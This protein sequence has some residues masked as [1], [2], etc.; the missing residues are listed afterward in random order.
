MKKIL[1]KIK[2]LLLG[3]S[4]TIHLWVGLILSFSSCKKEE[5]FPGFKETASGLFYKLQGIGDG[6]K[7]PVIGDYLKLNIVYKTSKDS[8]FILTDNNISEILPL[9]KPTFRGSFEEGLALLNEADSATYLVNADSMFSKFFKAELPSF[10]EKGS[11]MK[12]E[13]K[14]NKIL[15]QQQYNQELTLQEELIE[16]RD[17]EEQ[18]TLLK[19]LNKNN[20]TN[21]PIENGLYYIPVKEGK[22][23]NVEQGKTLVINYKG[24]FLDGKLFDSTY[25]TE[26]MEFTLMDG[27]S[28]LIKGLEK[29]IC[30]MKEG[31]K[32]K[33]II[34]SLL[35][36]SEKGSSTS[37]VP[38][39]TTVIYEVELIK[40]VK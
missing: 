40:V 7:K 26:P 30:L 13:V 24:F 5:K 32:A 12:I 36:F 1:Q 18:K 39:Y 31:G 9:R 23:T 21:S 29:G 37:I 19:Y 2:N 33:F 27:Q 17:V 8:S 38:P 3:P 28:Q 20:I 16:D 22:G 15:N 4:S 25:E 35:A 6:T 10:I 34:S 11:M 14:L